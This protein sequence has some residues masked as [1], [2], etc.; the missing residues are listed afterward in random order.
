M[1]AACNQAFKQ[2]KKGDLDGAVQSLTTASKIDPRMYVAIYRRG[3]IMQQHELEQAI[4]D[5]NTALTIRQGVGGT[6]PH[7]QFAA[8]VSYRCPRPE[9]SSLALF[10]L[11]GSCLSQW[12]AGCRRCHRGV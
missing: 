6:D 8:E 11:P 7:H 2:V 5:F 1:V 9:R 4:A 12:Q 3:T 10:D